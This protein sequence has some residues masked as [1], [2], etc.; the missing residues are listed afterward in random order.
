MELASKFISI[1][2]HHIPRRY[3]ASADYIAS[4]VLKKKEGII[5]T[6]IDPKLP[7]KLRK[8]IPSLQSN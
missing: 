8:I 3:S 4:K 5:T 6:E 2:L 1:E 7:K